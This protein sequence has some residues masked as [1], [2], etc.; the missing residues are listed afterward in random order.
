MKIN[1][2]NIELRMGGLLQCG[3][4]L[5]AASMLAGGLIYLARHGG[6][7][8][9]YGNFH[10]VHPNFKTFRGILSG[11]LA[12]QGRALIQLGVLLMIATPVMRVAFAVFAFALER[13]WLYTGVSCVV[14]VVLGYALLS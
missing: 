3:V 11:V 4:L 14:L 7:I 9:D 2:A 13:D 1:D 6:D 12:L 5:A 10:G 8:P